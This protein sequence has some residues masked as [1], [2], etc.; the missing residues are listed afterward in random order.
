MAGV[1]F[2]EKGIHIVTFFVSFLSRWAYTA[3]EEDDGADAALVMA[4]NR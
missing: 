3:I 2:S 1:R 4:I